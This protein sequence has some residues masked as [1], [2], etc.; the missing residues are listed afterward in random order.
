MPINQDAPNF[1]H[2]VQTAASAYLSNG[3]CDWSDLY[4]YIASA[5]LDIGIP[6]PDEVRKA[7]EGRV[8]FDNKRCMAMLT[9]GLFDGQTFE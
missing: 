9:Y 4:Q 7:L 3:P 6:D 2:E 8:I 1:N 5:T